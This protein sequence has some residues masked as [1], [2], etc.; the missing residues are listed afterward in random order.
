MNRRAF[1]PNWLCLLLP[2]APAV[3]AATAS[4]GRPSLVAALESDRFFADI[5]SVPRF[6]ITPDKSALRS[7]RQNPRKYVPVEIAVEGVEFHNVGIHLKAGAG[8]FRPVDDKPALTL[9]F[10]KFMDKQRFHGLEKIHLNNS[11]QDPAWMTEIVCGELFLAAGVPTARATHA[12]VELAGRPRGLYVLKEGY[13][14]T[15]LKRY[16]ADPNGN[17]YDGGF[18]RDIN[19]PLD[20]IGR[21]DPKPD[22]SDMRSLAAACS[23]HDLAK[24]RERVE[25]LLDIDRFITFAALEVMTWHWDGYCMKTNNYRV[26]HDPQADKIVF[27]PHGMDQM[28]GVPGD[29]ING[30]ISAPSGGLVARAVFEVPEWR[31]RYYQRVAEL[32]NTIFLPDTMDRRIDELAAKVLPV[33]KEIDKG[34]ARDFPNRIKWLKNQ[35]HKRADSIDKQLAERAKRGR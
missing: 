24:R 3:F 7:L 30:P 34:T 28:F 9:N 18:L 14:R 23:E 22:S 16:F 13:D 35:I 31:K 21:R 15:F 20:P 6:V 1:P 4:A 19:Q 11:V 33:L 10:G 12:V 2:V 17:L 29:D 25:K 8:S 5:K 32:R 27:I 26:Y